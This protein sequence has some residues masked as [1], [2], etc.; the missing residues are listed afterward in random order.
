M[1]LAHSAR[2]N[3]AGR[4]V[5]RLCA[6]GCGGTEL[7]KS[8]FALVR[9]KSPKFKDEFIREYDRRVDGEQVP[10]DDIERRNAIARQVLADMVANSPDIA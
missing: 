3:T 4:Q 9:E 2:D 5:E 7:T 10:F 8:V 6:D 1:A